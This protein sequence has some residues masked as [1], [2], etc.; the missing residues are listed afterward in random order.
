MKLT[1][2]SSLDPVDV[3]LAKALL[4]FVAR[5]RAIREE[6]ASHAVAQMVTGCASNVL[7]QARHASSCQGTVNKPGAIEEP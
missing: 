6:H 1:K 3:A 5:G 2:A 4:V 7:D